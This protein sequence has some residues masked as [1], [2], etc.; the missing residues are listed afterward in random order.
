M[1]VRPD[2]L[3]SIGKIA[4]EYNIQPLKE[5]KSLPADLQ[6]ARIIQAFQQI[7]DYYIINE[8][9][10]T[11]CRV[12]SERRLYKSLQTYCEDPTKRELVADYDTE[13]IIDKAKEVHPEWFVNNEKDISEENIN[14]VPENLKGV[15]SSAAFQALMKGKELGGKSLF[16]GQFAKVKPKEQNMPDYIARRK[17]CEEFDETFKHLF[18]SCQKD[19]KAGARTVI[20]FK[21]EQHIEAGKFYVLNGILAYV[22]DKGEAF[23]KGKYTNYRL[24]II[25]IN[26]QESD[27]LLRSFSTELYKTGYM[28]SEPE[29]Q[30]LPGMTITHEDQVTGWIYVLSSQ[31][32]QQDI[33]SIDNLH[34][35][36]FSTKPVEQ[37]IANSENQT[38]YLNA[39]VKIE[40]SYK[41]ANL[42]TKAFESLLHLIFGEVKIDVDVPDKYGKIH[43]AT[44]WFIVPIEVIME[45]VPYIINGSID[46][47]RYNAKNQKLELI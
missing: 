27:M 14:K 15:A 35:I 40:A 22:A 3:E 24:R 38:T 39:P 30:V 29:N 19:I 36:G 25:F 28:V 41:C 5:Q 46:N 4:E 33:R 23:K 9:L 32:T 45:A 47:Y 18:A 21:R 13:S 37:R 12:V 31:S 34:K 6:K 26:G 16:G 2:V 8:R 7:L 43:K 44:E 20:K 10:P 11:K 42:K 17:P 1:K